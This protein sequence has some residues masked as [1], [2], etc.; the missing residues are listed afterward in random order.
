MIGH[1]LEKK[2]KKKAIPTISG[3]YFRGE[4]VIKKHS[5]VDKRLMTFDKLLERYANKGGQ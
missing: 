4:R 2:R 3:L 1:N 5:K